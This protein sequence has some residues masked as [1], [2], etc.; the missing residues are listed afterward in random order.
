MNPRLVDLPLS[1]VHSSLLF[2]GVGFHRSCHFG[3]SANRD[4]FSLD[5]CVPACLALCCYLVALR[6]RC[7]SAVLHHLSLLFPLW[8]SPTS[9]PSS[10][11]F[12]PPLLVPSLV[13]PVVPSGKPLAPGD[14]QLNGVAVL[15]YGFSEERFYAH[16]PARME[17]S[18]P[19]PP[20]PHPHT[21]S[22][23]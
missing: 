16:A 10:L 7:P 19:P 2:F 17:L 8:L 9:L 18:G 3:S 20:S 11:A 12:R 6:A 14:L 5:V 23:R 22:C 13:R 1:R 4:C 15:G 21:C